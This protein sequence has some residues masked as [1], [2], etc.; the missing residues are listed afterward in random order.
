MSSPEQLWSSVQFAAADGIDVGEP[1]VVTVVTI[2]CVDVVEAPIVVWLST[3][4]VV[5]IAD[6]LLVIVS[7]DSTAMLVT[8]EVTR[9][10]SNVVR[11]T[12]MV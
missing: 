5:I 2:V 3:V 6:P 12:V 7:V 4:P 10:V 9:M 11:G 8:V 1:F